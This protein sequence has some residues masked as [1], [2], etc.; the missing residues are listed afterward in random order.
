M[1]IHRCPILIASALVWLS[2]CDASIGSSEHQAR[3]NLAHYEGWLEGQ[4]E[5]TD[6]DLRVIGNVIVGRLKTGE[7]TVLPL[8][9]TGAHR[10]VVIASCDEA[11]ADLDM[12]VVTEDGRLIGLDEDP[13]ADPRVGIGRRK[14]DKLRLRVRM[15]SCASSSCTF[16]AGQYEFAD[17]AGSDG[18]C[19]AVSPDG[20]LLTSLHVV[21]GAENVD[22]VF[23]DG[24]RAE[25]EVFR[26][27]EDNDL[28]LLRA[29]VRTPAWLPLG[30]EEDIKVGMPA[31]TVGY[32]ATGKLGED[33]KFAEGNV[34]ALSGYEGEPTLLQVYMPIQ[35]GNSGGP[36]VSFTGRVVG[37]VESG[38]E[39]D[40]NG[41]ALQL[42][43]FAR[44]ARVAAL[45]LPTEPALP[46]V[47]AAQ[48]RAQAV[49]RATRAV[50]KVEARG[51]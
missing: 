25:A 47:P 9:I 26:R 48:S 28:A 49:A 1:P 51:G 16:A 13:D 46:A 37:I 33:A 20:L 7:E 39:R 4:S 23:A 24:R 43:N 14:P 38:V 6:E 11:C 42:T 45:M 18:T 21:D 17:Y 31:F 40:E 2:G 50:C 27:S 44:N 8:E 10:A 29:D 5:A 22:V 12:R 34:A 35:R 15:E 32:P 36:V 41:N 3:V 30:G 19:F